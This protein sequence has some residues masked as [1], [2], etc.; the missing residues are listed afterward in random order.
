MGENTEQSAGDALARLAFELRESGLLG[1]YLWDLR[2][3]DESIFA[4]EA[5]QP[6]LTVVD[7]TDTEG[8]DRRLV[9]P[10]GQWS[11]AL[12]DGFVSLRDED[13][14]EL[15]TSEDPPSP[16]DLEW[17]SG[18]ALVQIERT[19]PAEGELHDASAGGSGDAAVVITLDLGG[20][21]VLSSTTGSLHYVLE[22]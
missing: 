19:E 8:R 14:T 12:H 3:G 15:G 17:L 6:L 16:D 10:R 13:G 22:G 7:W 5:G 11:F 18:Q 20:E 1:R 4:F 9:R 2:L 21:I